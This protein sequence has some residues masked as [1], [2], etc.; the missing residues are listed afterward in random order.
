LDAVSTSSARENITQNLPIILSIVAAACLVSF[1]GLKLFD[2][3]LQM[4]W[5]VSGQIIQFMTVMI[6]LSVILALGLASFLKETTLGTL[7]GGVAGYV[8][9]QGV[10]RQAARDATRGG[11]ASPPRP[12]VPPLS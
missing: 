3:E 5:V 2:P 11:A 12:V 10:G 6:L 1:V 9:A 8:L 4:E 7:L